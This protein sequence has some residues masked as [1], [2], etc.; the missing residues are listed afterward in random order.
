MMRCRSR[1]ERKE[2]VRGV[3]IACFLTLLMMRERECVRCDLTE[4][5]YN[6]VRRR[7]TVATWN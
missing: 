2:E 1:V 3:A 5:L 7:D 6:S 4:F